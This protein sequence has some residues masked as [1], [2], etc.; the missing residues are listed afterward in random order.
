VADRSGCRTFAGYR[1]QP[2]A[3]YEAKG[4]TNAGTA[5]DY[6]GV[7]FPDGTV[8]VRWATT[9]Q[10]HSVWACWADFHHVHG[11]PEYGTLIYF[12]DDDPPPGDGGPWDGNLAD[13]IKTVTRVRALLAASRAG[14][15]AG[16][17]PPSETTG[18]RT[19]PVT[20]PG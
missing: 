13:A 20:G 6:W 5:A 9:W 7:I 8:T 19:T 4:I 17:P 14:N 16:P 11:H 10:S 18:R 15:V 12:D 2:P 1:P 3:E